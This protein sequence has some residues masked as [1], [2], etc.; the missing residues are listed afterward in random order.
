MKNRDRLLQIIAEADGS[1]E[2]YD[3]KMMIYIVAAAKESGVDL[4]DK[5]S[6]GAFLD[7]LKALITRDKASLMA[8]LRKY[9]KK[10]AKQ[11]GKLALKA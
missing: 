8:A 7:S 5:E 2:D 9:A 3:P 4:S 10:D 6:V 1:D 11:L